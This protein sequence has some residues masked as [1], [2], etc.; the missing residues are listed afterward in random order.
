MTYETGEARLTAA[1][2]AQA[3]YYD[4]ASIAAIAADLDRSYGYTRRLLAT[5]GT[6][7]RPRGRQTA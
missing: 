7:F 4:G 1:R 6:Q 2:D 3:R 5:V